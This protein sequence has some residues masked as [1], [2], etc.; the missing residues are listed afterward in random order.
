MRFG[1][2]Q[3]AARIEDRRFLTGQGRYVD[4][5][6]PRDARLGG[7]PRAP[8]AQ[9]RIAVL[10]LAPARAMPGVQLVLDAGGLTAQG[11][12]LAMNGMR[13]AGRGGRP[14][15][16]P[17]RPTLALGT[18]RHLGEPVAMVVA[19]T[20]A[21]ARDAAEAI[22]LEIEEAPPALEPRPGLPAVHPEAA[23]VNL[24]YDFVLGDE[25]AAAQALAGAAL[26]VAVTVAQPRITAAPMEPRAAFAE[27]NGGRL[28]LCTCAQGVWTQKAELA[29]MLRL[30]PDRIRVTN[31]DV[32]GGFGMKVMTYPEYVPLAQAA[33][34]LGRAVRWT[35]D[36]SESMLAD[37]G[38]RDLEATAEIGFGADH[39]I[40][41]YRCAVRSNLGA[42]NSQFG[43]N[44]QSELFA[45]VFTGIYHI[46]A[47]S[48]TAQG[49]YT[50]TTP[51]DAYRG[52]GR[53]EAILTIERAM[54]A[55]AR[56]LSVSPFALRRRN[57]I[58]AFPYRMANGETVHDG[59]FAGLLD[60]LE[61]RCDFAGL[62][63]RRAESRARGLI[64]G[65]GLAAYLEAIL[66]DQSEAATVDLTE[67]GGATLLVG[68]L[69]N[70]QGHETVYTRLLA[71]RT[72]LPEGR[73]RIVQGDSD[74]IPR[75]GG[76][77]G[78]RSVTLQGTATLATVKA[79]TDAFADFLSAEMGEGVRFDGTAFTAPGTN[80]RPTLA[81]AAAKARA[82]G[83]GD[84]MR[85][86][87]RIDM[88]ARSFPN[89]AHAAE[90]ELDPETGALR[91][92]RYTVVDDFGTMLA[93]ALVEGQVQGGIAQGFG[94]VILERMVH[95]RHGQL[96]TGSFMDYAV[97]R[98]ADLPRPDLSFRP[99]PTGTNP[100]GMKGCGEAGTV[101]S[102]AA[103]ANAVADA[104]AEA[105]AP[106]M[107][108]PH[109]PARIWTHLRE[110]HAGHP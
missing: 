53:P 32:G 17:M 84:L 99:V 33:R 82:A 78:S 4:D 57:A 19:D 62:P 6:A 27:W 104:L 10:D 90:V 39:R 45:K 59:D 103:L 80:L 102:L 60:R 7:V 5:L 71:E 8:R 2:A 93:P 77:G 50:H 70:G 54:D 72:G 85:H 91:V 97:P 55:A 58:A 47:P 31:P 20:L 98:A 81:E 48:L 22:G 87:A 66:G 92:D 42:Y 34:M 94:Q 101:G 100:L 109:T 13:I 21:Q 28:H 11:I 44:I 73:I 30:A 9:G 38:A 41:G 3:T 110:A 75:G 68:T 52:A 67:D 24:A 51:V 106:P 74:A 36:R 65:F 40:T 64:R 89:G 1:T 12:R 18:V 88:A 86:H 76:T 49:F 23:P 63:A 105:G 107:D 25:N 83:R 108:M 46:P 79:M 15:A 26:R 14:G 61:A 37:N 35:A 43:Q 29:R 96:L 16:G 95:D 56:A 69:S